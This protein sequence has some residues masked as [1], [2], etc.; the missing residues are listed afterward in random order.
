MT[1]RVCV[2]VR[3]RERTVDFRFDSNEP[4]L[5]RLVQGIRSKYS[6]SHKNVTRNS[7]SR[8]HSE[9]C[10]Y[11]VRVSHSLATQ[12]IQMV[13][14]YACMSACVLVC[15]CVRELSYSFQT[16]C[17][18]ILP[19]IQAVIFICA[20]VHTHTHTPSSHIS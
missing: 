5:I 14:R 13:L 19:T 7:I 17:I 10:A 15:V 9:P 20:Q 6:G 16:T 11:L 2:C 12:S 8:K 18:P 3:D 4:P 1:E